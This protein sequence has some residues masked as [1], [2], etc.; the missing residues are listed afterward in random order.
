[1]STYI[2]NLVKEAKISSYKLTQLTTKDKNKALKNMAK[3]LII[4][5]D[6]ILRENKK[7]IAQAVKNNLKKSFIDRLSLNDKRLNEMS[8]SLKA[9]ASLADPIGKTISSKKRPNQMVVK[10]SEFL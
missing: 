2:K 6:F 3:A 8:A 9:V 7:D 10:R 1:M 4:E 5:K